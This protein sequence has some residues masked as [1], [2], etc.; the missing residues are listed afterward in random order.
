MKNLWF[1]W[2]LW[3]SF[4]AAAAGNAIFFTVFDPSDLVMFGEPVH[5]SRIGVYSIGFFSLW[6]ITIL[7]NVLTY[8]LQK[9]APEIN[10]F[11]FDSSPPP[12]AGDAIGDEGR[13]V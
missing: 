7:S 2:I 1:I 5:A 6:A 4:L 11:P 12:P 13:R 8:F 9:S 3:P 10:H